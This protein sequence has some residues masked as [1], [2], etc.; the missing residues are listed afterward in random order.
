MPFSFPA[1]LY[2]IVDTLGDPQRSHLDLA[3][4][5]LAAGTPLLQLRVKLQPTGRC[6]ELARAVQAEADRYGA[7]LLINDRADIA[8][9]VGAA[10]VHLGQDDLPVP[11]ARAILGP[12]AIIG[13]STHTLAQ[14][15][16]AAR[17][18]LA[19]YLGF[20][21]IY[22]TRSKENPDPVQGLDGL[23]AVRPR[24]RLPLVA[25]GGI[26]AANMNDV[27]GAGAD[28]VAMIGDIVRAG[29]VTETVRALLEHCGS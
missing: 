10:G 11:A 8:A 25:I 22:A 9:L 7:L 28:A 21:P 16:S 29:D 15:E 20:G 4:A 2:P 26:T 14:A 17:H 13:F 24:I 5:V 27:L 6:V 12:R 1:R 23:R 3:R 19:D 18:G